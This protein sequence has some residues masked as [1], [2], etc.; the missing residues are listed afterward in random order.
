[1]RGRGGE[2]GGG[3]KGTLYIGKVC[4]VRESYLVV[5]LVNSGEAF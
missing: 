2:V 4:R 5:N 1:M 3:A